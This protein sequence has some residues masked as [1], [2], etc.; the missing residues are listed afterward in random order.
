MRSC[1]PCSRCT[2][3]HRSP[4]L[5]YLHDARRSL[6]RWSCTVRHHSDCT[7]SRRRCGLCSGMTRSRCIS[8]RCGSPQGEHRVRFCMPPCTRGS[9]YMNQL[10]GQSRAVSSQARPQLLRMPAHPSLGIMI[11]CCKCVIVPTL[12]VLLM[13][14]EMKLFE[15]P[16]LFVLWPARRHT[17]R[18]CR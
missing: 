4:P 9:R 10:Q 7:A 13:L 2:V 11:W 6:G 14:D 18:G 1:T 3:N 12:W 8:P 16:T 17:L 15:G 5:R